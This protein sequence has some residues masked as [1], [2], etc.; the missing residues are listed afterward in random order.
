M[1]KVLPALD[2][3]FRLEEATIGELHAAI[4]A[5]ATTCVAV[6]QTYIARVRAYNGVASALVTEEGAPVAPATGTVRAGT[7]LRFPTET[8]KASTLLPDLDKYTGPPL[9]Y[10][11]M[12]ATASDPR[13]AAA[14]RHDRRYSQRRPGERARDAEHPRRALGHLPR[15]FRSP[16]LAGIASVRCAAGVRIL[17]PFSRCARA[18]RRARCPV[19]STSRSRHVADVRRRVLVQGS[20][21]HQGHALHR[22]GRR[23]LRHRFPGARP[24]A[25][26]AAAQQGRHHLRQ[27]SEHRIQ[28]ARRRSRRPPQASQGAAIHP[29][30]SAQHLGRQSVQSLRHHARCI[31]RL[32]LRVGALGQHQHGDGQPRRGDS[33]LLP[34]PVQPQCGGPD[35]AAQGDVGLRRGRHRSGHLL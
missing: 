32:E 19:R 16:P 34:R 18:R 8:V 6:V 13:R 14:V 20:V 10:G 33:R 24:R 7:A 30:L 26:R 25:G 4:K 1:T 17:S 35:P 5:G 11:R 27:G 22:W 29:R 15:R 31:A 3:R 28:R 9:E 21:R 12:E 23:G 2:K